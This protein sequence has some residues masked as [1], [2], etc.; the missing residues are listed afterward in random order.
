MRENISASRNLVVAGNFNMT[1]VDHL[2]N[3]LVE[4][5]HHPV[6]KTDTITV[7]ERIGHFLDE[8]VDILVSK[9]KSQ[10]MRGIEVSARLPKN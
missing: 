3:R 6:A 10:G 4:M 2:Y 7:M 5:G 9:Y 8:E 1:N